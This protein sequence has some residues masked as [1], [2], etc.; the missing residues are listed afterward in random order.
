M[1]VECL[2]T[3]QPVARF[4]DR[5]ISPT[6]VDNLAAALLEVISPEFTYR[7]ILHLAGSQ[8]VTDYE[9]TRCLARCLGIDKKLVNPDYMVDSPLMMN[10]PRDNSL[11]TTFTQNL[12][13]NSL[14]GVEEQLLSIFP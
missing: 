8:R 9:Y 3:G 12:L 11:N 5:Y 4:C 7:G 10:S 1:P 13:K 6:L 2:Q 14:L